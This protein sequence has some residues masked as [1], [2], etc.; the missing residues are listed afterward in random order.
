MNLEAA[1]QAFYEETDELLAAMDAALLAVETAKE[2]ERSECINAMFRAAHTIKGSAGLFDYR[3]VV[4]F[5]H[6]LES[7]LD[8]LREGELALSSQL[9]QL[10]FAC[11]DHI[12]EL[13]NAGREGA[14]VVLDASLCAALERELHHE[15]VAPPVMASAASGPQ[16][17]KQAGHDH[18]VASDCWHISLR[19]GRDVLRNGMDPAS[20]IRYLGGLGRIVYLTTLYD[21]LPEPHLMDPE[22]CY[23]GFEIQFHAGPDIDKLAIENVFDF[24]RDDSKVRIV[25]PHAHL[26]EYI[27]LI[28]DMPEGAARLGELLV[29]GGA[30]TPLEL[31]EVLGLQRDQAASGDHRPLGTLLVEEQLVPPQAVAAALDKQR[32]QQT[33]KTR[34]HRVVRVD[35]TRLDGLIDLVGELVIAG[36]AAQL[37]SERTGDAI[38]KEALASL[39]E[40]V[41]RIRDEA[42]SLRMVP[43]NEI[44]GRFPRVVRDASKELNKDI[45][46]Y[47]EGEETELDKSMVDKLSDPLIHLIRN[48]IDHGIEPPERRR[49]T[50]KAD[51]G[52]VWLNAYHESGSVVIEVGDD[53]GGMDRERIRAR[54]I[55]RGLIGADE[56]LSDQAI[57]QLVF[58][59]GFSTAETVTS[60][61]G[62]GVGMD[63]V[64]RNIEA[65]KGEIDIQSELGQ[66]T[67]VRLR[68]PLTLAIIDGFRVAV[69]KSTFVIPLDLVIECLDL[70]ASADGQRHYVN[71]RGEV[72]PFLRLRELF[73]IEGSAPNRQAVV[74]VQ[75]GM[76]RAGLVVDRLEG[77]LQAVIKPLGQLFRGVKGLGG[78][79][80]LGS[81]AVALILDV[82]DLIQRASTTERNR[83]LAV[84]VYEA[85]RLGVREGNG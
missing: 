46:L 54:G 52:T 11:R 37:A 72:L 84:P 20:F 34:E 33:H 83:V 7:V 59:P 63:V 49:A 29:R 18:A 1:R 16:V 42:L 81:G 65:L 48:A 50:G 6:L 57:L 5:T 66:G 38:L 3:E 74:V 41:E 75:Y 4:T 19:F 30:L 55:E 2:P 15:N 17:I 53:G 58:E 35:A 79:T 26:T 13:V 44:F 76:N 68:L 43:V 32:E 73:D 9:V 61:S 80:I 64:K 69:G 28:H 40:L 56:V 62:R 67:V 77:E 60:L 36:A 82:P 78:S 45:Q 22:S 25:P 71:L 70:P 8:Q 39:G 51:Y 14:P 12:D 10:L 21:D 27:R 47:I 31:E 85:R 23:L 24:V